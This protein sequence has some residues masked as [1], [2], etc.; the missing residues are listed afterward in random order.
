MRHRL[1]L[2]CVVTT[3]G[4]ASP[5]LAHEGHRAQP[6]AEAKPPAQAAPPPARAPAPAQQAA[7]PSEEAPPKHA[8]GHGGLGH[9]ASW[10]GRWHP[11][12][13]HF[14]IALL[15]A[16]AAAEVLLALRPGA[17]LAGTVRFCIAAGALLAPLA[18]ALG[19]LAAG[20]VAADEDWV[21]AA[22]RWGGSATALLALALL[23]ASERALRSGERGRL[24][25]ALGLVA[26][27]AIATGFLGGSLVHG[28][29]HLAWPAP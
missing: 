4:G 6:S 12:A 13:V 1:L 15:L 5:A 19:W 14:P 7:A 8:W 10:L 29:D 3:L 11:S 25:L 21:V 18:A 23:A 26:A 16:A 2:L 28:L 24:R 22:H 20:P 27:S 9:L 17:S